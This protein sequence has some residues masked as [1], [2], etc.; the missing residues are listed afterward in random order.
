MSASGS[1]VIVSV[2]AN[3]TTGG[4]N[5]VQIAT[6][7]GDSALAG[8]EADLLAAGDPDRARLTNSRG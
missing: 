5:F 7:T 3:G 1:N 2:D 8:H 4:A 6:L